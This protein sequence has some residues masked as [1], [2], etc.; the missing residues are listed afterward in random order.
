MSMSIR[1]LGFSPLALL[2]IPEILRWRRIGTV[3]KVSAPPVP[4]SHDPPP[5]AL[6]PPQPPSFPPLPSPPPSHPP[7]L[8]SHPHLQTSSQYLL[9]LRLYHRTSPRSHRK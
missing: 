6:P 3:G 7:F 2:L 5:P 1:N 9:R 8:P 4:S